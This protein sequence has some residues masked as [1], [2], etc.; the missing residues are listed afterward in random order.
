MYW[1]RTRVSTVIKWQIPARDTLGFMTEDEKGDTSS[2]QS[3]IG[4]YQ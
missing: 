2:V 3:G 1:Y 4:D